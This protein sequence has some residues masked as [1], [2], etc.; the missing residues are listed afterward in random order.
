MSKFIERA[1]KDHL[2]FVHGLR[3]LKKS[4]FDNQGIDVFFSKSGLGLTIETLCK[5]YGAILAGGVFRSLF[6][7]GKLNGEYPNPRKFQ[8]LKDFDIYF[9]NVESL[10]AATEFI[11]RFDTV[12]K[13]YETNNCIAFKTP[14]GTFEFIKRIYGSPQIILESF[15]YIVIQAALF[16]D[17]SR[18][19]LRIL[20]NEWLYAEMHRNEINYSDGYLEGPSYDTN[21]LARLVRYSEYGYGFNHATLMKTFDFSC[22][23][24]DCS[25]GEK[26]FSGWTVERF[27]KEAN[28]YLYAIKL[29]LAVNDRDA[30]YSM[31]SH[32]IDETLHR[33]IHEYGD[34]NHPVKDWSRERSSIIDAGFTA[35]FNYRNTHWDNAS[36][37]IRDF[38]PGWVDGETFIGLNPEVKDFIEIL[39]TLKKYLTLD[40]RAKLIST[41]FTGNLT[42]DASIVTDSII[43]NKLVSKLNERNELDLLGGMINDFWLSASRLTATSWMDYIDGELFDPKLPS[44]FVNSLFGS[45]HLTVNYTAIGFSSVDKRRAMYANLTERCEQ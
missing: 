7:Q 39:P 32:I 20:E 35:L 9:P 6:F 42:I 29:H 28:N 26:G 37:V 18:K 14:Y 4:V 36:F 19:E 13:I 34:L 27:K 41:I 17:D 24:Y 23:K 38:V 22:K 21:P 1:A 5:N 44:I 11:S 10:E 16:W 8:S 30:S 15:D 40:E 12:K 31:G 33:F 3:K 43:M 25:F 2:A 45:S